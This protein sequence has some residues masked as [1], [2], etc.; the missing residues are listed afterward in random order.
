[1]FGMYDAVVP[2]RGTGVEFEYTDMSG[3]GRSMCKTCFIMSP[4]ASLDDAPRDDDVGACAL[5][6]PRAREETDECASLCDECDF[7]REPLKMLFIIVSSWP[8]TSEGWS[9]CRPP[10]NVANG[11][12]PT[13]PSCM[14]VSL[15]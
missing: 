10:K 9:S 4:I 2:Q 1:M 7:G 6:R 11:S 15:A 8:N 3:S 12:C 5:L 14:S 13:P